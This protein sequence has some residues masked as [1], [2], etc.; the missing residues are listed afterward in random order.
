MIDRGGDR[1]SGKRDASNPLDLVAKR[2]DDRA[3]TCESE[4]EATSLVSACGKK[5]LCFAPGKRP[6]IDGL[7]LV[8]A[9]G[10]R[11]YVLMQLFRLKFA[12][13]WDASI[14]MKT[15]AEERGSFGSI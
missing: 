9:D 12:T 10:T 4:A 13:T 8:P 14:A 11:F 2:R 15:E 5:G 1:A 7:K 6:R 3:I